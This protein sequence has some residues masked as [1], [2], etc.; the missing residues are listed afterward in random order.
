MQHSG[1]SPTLPSLSSGALLGSPVLAALPRLQH[2]DLRQQQQQ[3]LLQQQQQQLQQQ[4]QQQQQQL[5]QQQLQQQQQQQQLLHARR[6]AEIQQLVVEYSIAALAHKKN[7][8][9]RDYQAIM[10][11]LMTMRERGLIYFFGFGDGRYH[12]SVASFQQC[13]RSAGDWCFV[14]SEEAELKRMLDRVSGVVASTQKKYYWVSGAKRRY[15]KRELPSLSK[16]VSLH[17]IIQKTSKDLSRRCA[18]LPGT[19][20][21]LV[22]W[23]PASVPGACAQLPT[24]FMPIT[25]PTM[26]VATA[27]SSA[28]GTSAHGLAVHARPYGLLPYL[29]A[30]VPHQGYAS[31]GGARLSGDATMLAYVPSSSSP[32]QLLVSSFSSVQC[33]SAAAAAATSSSPSASTTSS[34]VTL[35]S[36]LSSSGAVNGSQS[37]PPSRGGGYSDNALCDY[38]QQLPQ[39]QQA[40]LQQHSAPPTLSVNPFAGTSLSSYAAAAPSSGSPHR[41]RSLSAHSVEAHGGAGVVPMHLS[42]SP[43]SQQ[44]LLQRLQ[45]RPRRSSDA[46][47]RARRLSVDEGDHPLQS[48]SFPPPA[49]VSLNTTSRQLAPLPPLIPAGHQKRSMSTFREFGCNGLGGETAKRSRVS[50]ETLL[51]ATADGYP[52]SDAQTDVA[53]IRFS[54]SAPSLGDGSGGDSN[55]LRVS[56]EQSLPLSA[57]PAAKQSTV[58]PS[59]R[60][61]PSDVPSV[62]LGSTV[63]MNPANY[64]RNHSSSSSSVSSASS[65]IHANFSLVS[66]G[67]SSR[68]TGDDCQTGRVL[69]P[70][71]R[72]SVQ[73]PMR[74]SSDSGT[75]TYPGLVPVA[76]FGGGITS[77]TSLSHNEPLTP[78]SS[79]A[80][81]SLSLLSQ[82]AYKSE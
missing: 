41:E 56:S 46:E 66:G 54:R 72:I 67:S 2:P 45:Q 6:I 26:S 14:V 75:A 25:S 49:Y 81:G 78:T 52:S 65:S 37:F 61:I 80:A 44:R 15:L 16:P 73:E 24:A 63:E 35:S 55:R 47:Q 5:Q 68:Q 42:L 3:L 12:T 70:L 76:C 34:P 60:L 4:Q 19:N 13:W 31:G 58:M 71:S 43:S 77:A 30:P 82:V 21:W 7:H 8:G 57:V 48:T 33:S 23:V 69:P 29:P 39:A 18:C 11:F 79:A 20:Q 17:Y 32:T 74:L 9:K 40:R 64:R 53:S 22:L 59:M 38:Q 50:P 51:T 10:S 27:S 36:S 62:M 28:P 1:T